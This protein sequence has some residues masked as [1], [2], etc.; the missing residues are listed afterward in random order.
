MIRGHDVCA[1]KFESA[2]GADKALLD[3]IADTYCQ[4]FM[5]CL[6]K[7]F[8]TDIQRLGGIYFW[9][10]TPEVIP[11]ATFGPRT[12][13]MRQTKF[14]LST[15]KFFI[16]TWFFFGSMVSFMRC[17]LLVNFR[18]DSWKTNNRIYYIKSLSNPLVGPPHLRASL[19][20]GP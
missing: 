7:C 20:Y 18:D 16:L 15:N 6:A 3:A 10:V 5:K 14:Y 11:R 19:H 17:S 2:V 4:T 9:S 1:L 13:G 8:F 12:P